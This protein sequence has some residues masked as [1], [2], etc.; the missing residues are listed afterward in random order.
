MKDRLARERN[1]WMC[2]LRPDG[3]PHQTPVWFVY[4][5]DVWWVWSSERSVKVRNILADPR[6]SLALEDGDEPV[7]A[8]GNAVLWRGGYPSEVIAAFAE[9]YDGWDITTP[10]EGGGSR[11]VFEVKVRRWL[12]SGV[13]Q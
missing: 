7:V 6:V 10:F 1:A 2:T 13:A 4:L 11:V 12:L 5:G 3:P 8:E 9:K